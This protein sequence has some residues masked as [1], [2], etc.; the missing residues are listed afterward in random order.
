MKLHPHSTDF[1][2]N[3][4]FYL[5]SDCDLNISQEIFVF[6]AIERWIGHDPVSRLVSF[7]FSFF[8]EKTQIWQ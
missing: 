5:L 4:L 8:K 1:S 6:S 3:L 2:S 7:F